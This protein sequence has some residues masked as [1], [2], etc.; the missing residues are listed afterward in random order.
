MS[1][2]NNDWTYCTLSIYGHDSDQVIISEMERLVQE[3][4]DPDDNSPLS[5]FQ[6]VPIPACLI[7]TCYK[8]GSDIEYH[9]TEECG[10][11][12]LHYFTKK[13]WGTPF[14]ADSVMITDNGEYIQYEFRVLD[15]HPLPWLKE[16]SIEFPSLFFEIECEN[17]MELWDSFT[18]TV[19][20]GDEIDTYFH[21]KQRKKNG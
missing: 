20:N 13:C 18:T 2:V 4:Q 12:Y 21:K 6:H 11:P 17:E 15:G 8:I 10:Y 7:E 5:F 16:M 14:D 1:V 9:N 3:L 19:M